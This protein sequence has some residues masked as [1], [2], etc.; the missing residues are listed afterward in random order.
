LCD[1]FVSGREVTD[2]KTGK[3]E[4]KSKFNL[5][6]VFDRCDSIES[7]N[8]V[9]QQQIHF[10]FRK[11]RE[12]GIK[13]NIVRRITELCGQNPKLGLWKTVAS[14]TYGLLIWKVSDP[15]TWQDSDAELYH[16][17]YLSLGTYVPK[18][19]CEHSAYNSP[20]IS[21][22]KLT[23]FLINIV[24]AADKRLT[25]SQLM[26]VLGY[27]LEINEIQQESLDE[28]TE[29][30]NPLLETIAADVRS[31]EED[32]VQ[33]EE[34]AKHRKNADSF[35]TDLP[36]NLQALLAYR[37][38]DRGSLEDYSRQKDVPLSTLY[39]QLKQ[40][41]ARFGKYAKTPYEQRMI[42]QKLLEKLSPR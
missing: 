11:T 7:A 33:Q 24:T 16:L 41:K 4:V 12:I 20:E 32:L 37:L 8:A 30:K 40:I 34:E 9:V 23:E 27:K 29:K 36:G 1:D 39:D 13:E 21:N 25:M 15:G 35:F 6:E 31:P 18:T 38:Q 28:E 26:Y 3:E 10:F 42:Q 14:T 22:S 2:R 17:V 5:P 19:Y